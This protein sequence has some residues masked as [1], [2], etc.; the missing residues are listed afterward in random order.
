MVERTSVI[1]SESQPRHAQHQSLNLYKVLS[2]RRAVLE[3]E[4]K[5]LIAN[6]SRHN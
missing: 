1:Q 3:V 2:D 5:E 6:G 4:F